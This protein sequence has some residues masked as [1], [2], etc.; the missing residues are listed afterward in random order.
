MERDQIK[1]RLNQ[2]F[3]EVFENEGLE[4]NEA[5]TARDVPGWDSLN[6][7]NLL[8]G[9]ENEFETIAEVV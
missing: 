9:V 2:V 7:V 8:A 6:H 1:Q 4:V 3:R 5:M